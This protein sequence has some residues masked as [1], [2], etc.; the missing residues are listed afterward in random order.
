MKSLLLLLAF[1]LSV[2]ASGQNN[3]K[4]WDK[5]LR[6]E[7]KGK[8][9]R[10]NNGT[11]ANGFATFYFKSD[12]SVFGVYESQSFK[13]DR[14]IDSSNNF[15]ANFKNDTVFRIVMHRYVPFEKPGRVILYLEGNKILAQDTSGKV[16]IPEVSKMIERAYQLLLTAKA[17][18]KEKA[19]K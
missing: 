18:I 6:K 19:M 2:I 11:R 5:D 10:I 1:S 13:T 15:S 3:V 17:L 16:F 14:R 4:D 12:K 8:F 9:K 7:I